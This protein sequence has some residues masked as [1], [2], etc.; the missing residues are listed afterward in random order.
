MIRIRLA[1]LL[2]LI[3]GLAFLFAGCQ[4]AAVPD[5][6]DP[7]TS[8]RVGISSNAPPFA[9]RQGGEVTGLEPDFALKLGDYLG[10]TVRFVE[11]PWDQQIKYLTEGKTDIIMSGMTIT[12]ARS[13]VVDFS[14][15]YLRS[16]QILLVRME[17]RRR[18]GTGVETPP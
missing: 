10:K 9:F 2:P 11:V 15:P 5:A 4:Q 3:V 8:L 18:F 14:I 13:A 6:V 12:Q 16:G 1:H 7:A 17:D